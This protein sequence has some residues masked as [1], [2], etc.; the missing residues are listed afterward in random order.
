MKLLGDAVCDHCLRANAPR[1]APT[2]SLPRDD[3]LL[4]L[5]GWYTKVPFRYGGMHYVIGFTHHASGTKKS[6]R[7]KRSRKS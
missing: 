1:L 4:C 6:Y 7:L 3:G 5:D 2:G